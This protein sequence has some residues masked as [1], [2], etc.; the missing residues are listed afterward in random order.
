VVRTAMSRRFQFSLKALLA[1]MV[2][3]AMIAA[4]VGRMAPVP[5]DSLAYVL[6]VGFAVAG[7]VAGLLSAN[8]F[9]G[10]ACAVC[11]LAS[12]LIIWL[13]YP[14]LDTVRGSVVTGL[15]WLRW[16]FIAP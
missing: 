13:I 10:V 14:A 7:I 9:R 2:P 15:D 16:Q 12:L 6:A 5:N 3:L 8:V 11:L 1:I 4:I